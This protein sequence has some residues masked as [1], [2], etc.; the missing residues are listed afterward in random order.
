MAKCDM[1]AV[2]ILLL[3]VSFEMLSFNMAGVTF[4][5]HPTHLLSCFQRYILK[6]SIATLIRALSEENPPSVVT[7]DHASLALVSLM[8]TCNIAMH[9]Q[10]T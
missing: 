3:V 6:K 5:L 2:L 4:N 7:G 1:V 9:I 10:S 8:Y